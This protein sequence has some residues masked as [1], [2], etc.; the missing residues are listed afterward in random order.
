[1]Y[2]TT[3]TEN[4]SLR[5]P[6]FV[7]ASNFNNGDLSG[8]IRLRVNYWRVHESTQ[9]DLHPIFWKPKNYQLAVR[10]N[11]SV[12]ACVGSE[13]EVDQFIGIAIDG[14]P[15]YGPKASDFDDLIKSTDLDACHG[16]FKD[17]KYRYHI[18]SDFPY[19]I[20]CYKGQSKNVTTH[21]LSSVYILNSSCLAQALKVA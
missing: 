13:T 1:M 2:I 6:P 20:G 3:W 17:G 15:L 16:R 8:H 4:V 5:H 11:N 14:N 7:P 10:V 9:S 18:T 19:I 12:S 21:Y